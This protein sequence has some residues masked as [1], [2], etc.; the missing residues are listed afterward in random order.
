FGA[1]PNANCIDTSDGRF[2]NAG[3]Q[4]GEPALPPFPP[5]RFWQ[6]RTDVN[7]G[8][9]RPLTYKINADA[10]TIE[11]SCPLFASTSSNDF[12]PAIVANENKTIFL[13][14]SSTD[15]VGP[16][17]RNAHVRISGKLDADAC[18]VAQTGVPLV[19]STAPLT[20]NFDRNFGAQR[21]GDYSAVTLD[22]AD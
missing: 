20:G 17:A 5:V 10:L 12:N 21:W 14:W 11:E 19:T 15:P 9:P 4:L 3:T 7:S 18:A 22:P 8:H 13:T 16:P 6:V 2:Q 1:C